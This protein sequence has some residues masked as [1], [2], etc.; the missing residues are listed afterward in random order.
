[1]V[2]FSLRYVG[3]RLLAERLGPNLPVFLQY[4]SGGTAIDQALLLF[5]ISVADVEREWTRRSAR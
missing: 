2:A 4:L 1:V 3:A 5:N